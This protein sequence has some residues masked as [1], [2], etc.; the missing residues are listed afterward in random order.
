M[1]GTMLWF[2]ADKGFGFIQT[3]DD[4]RLLVSS[5][6]FAADQQP[7]PRCKGRVVT[8]EREVTED[9]VHAV[10]VAFSERDEPR[11]A[12]LRKGRGGSSL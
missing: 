11:R 5:S 12:R 2:N 10:N 9:V 6:G 1:Q 8:F 3:E 7:P 4:E